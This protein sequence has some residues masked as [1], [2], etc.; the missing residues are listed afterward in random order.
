[1]LAVD[2]VGLQTLSGGDLRLRYTAADA[3]DVQWFNAGMSLKFAD[4]EVWSSAE[5]VSRF[6]PFVFNGTSGNDY[7]DTTHLDDV[8]YGGAGNDILSGLR[9]SDIL[10][11]GDGDVHD[12]SR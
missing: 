8:I 2:F 1:M 7:I 12:A 9:G 10:Y 5:L 3:V 4:G 11:G 6:G